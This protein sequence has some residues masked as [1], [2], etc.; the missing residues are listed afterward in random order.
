M[1]V[2]NLNQALL[3]LLAPTSGN[4]GE[5]VLDGQVKLLKKTVTTGR[6]QGGRP[7]AGLGR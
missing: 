5:P 6:A 3:D 1:L 4:P 2:E 7:R